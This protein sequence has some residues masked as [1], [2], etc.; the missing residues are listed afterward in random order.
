MASYVMTRWPGLN[1]EIR[2]LKAACSEATKPTW[3]FWVGRL[4]DLELIENKKLP[5]SKFAKPPS[6]TV[7]E[8]DLGGS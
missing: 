5:A 2:T 7:W 1:Q 6:A 3:A 4:L 8:T